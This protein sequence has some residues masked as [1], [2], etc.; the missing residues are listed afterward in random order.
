MIRRFIKDRLTTELTSPEIIILLGPRRIG[1]TTLLNSL[2]ET[3]KQNNITLY[4]DLTDP[5]ALALWK[6]FS[7]EKVSRLVGE[8]GTSGT[9]K[10]FFFDEIQY[11]PES[12]KLLKIFYDHF[13][14]VKVFATGSSSFL[15][16]QSIGESLAGRKKLI[17]LYPLALSE[18]LNM[19]IE[20]FWL[21][22]EHLLLTDKLNQQLENTLIFGAYP[23]V[24]LLANRENKAE[25]LKEI[26]DSILFK[27]LL[28]FEHIKKPRILVE[29]TK[30]LAYQ[31]GHLVN[32]SELAGALGVSRK[33]VLDYID[34]LER[35]FIIQ[36]VY[37]YEGNMRDVIRK[38]FKVYF[39]DLGIRNAVISDFRELP[40]RTDTGQLLENAVVMG[41]H[42]RLNYD[43]TLSEIYF[44]RDYDGKEVDLL[45][46]NQERFTAIEVK[47]NKIKE[48]LP[49]GFLKHFPQAEVFITNIRNAYR[50]CL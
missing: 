4:I 16:L 45:I 6:D 29:L 21:F 42:R 46:K 24:F 1:K 36:R 41:I 33:T 20:N 38:R 15:L 7:L 39:F 35:F 14:E 40:Q 47:L 12:G 19:D 28:M 43:H 32:P 26:T 18:I 8:M 2:E 34:L 22:Q 50:F 10:V 49:K 17:T 9:K 30:L 48:K 13:P 11:L 27:D 25:K 3:A 37:P 44:W 5:A 31:I 23:E